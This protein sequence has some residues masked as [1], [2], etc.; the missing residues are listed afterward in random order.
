MWRETGTIRLEGEAPKRSAFQ[1]II[2]GILIN[3]LNPKL[4]LFFFAF[5]PQFI[6]PEAHSPTTEMVGLSVVFM[7]MTLVIFI[8]YGILASWVSAAI[9]R[10]PGAVQNVTRSFALIFAV[11]AVKLALTEQ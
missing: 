9:L 11:L 5:L 2:K 7:L 8:M 3:I 10:S 1:I 6:S 4:A